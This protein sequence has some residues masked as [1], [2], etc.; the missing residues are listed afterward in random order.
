MSSDNHQYNQHVIDRLDGYAR[1][2]DSQFRIPLT[3]VRLGLDSLIGLL[4]GIGDGVAFLLS[5][6][7]LME[8]K[9]RGAP[10]T[11]LLKMLLNTLVDFVVGSI[12]L[13]GDIFDVGFK[14]NVRNVRLLKGY[15]RTENPL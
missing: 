10:L 14:A 8:A 11:I 5:L 4:P 7:P 3:P 6:Y 9:K 2:M 12:P 1:L 15:L 13:L